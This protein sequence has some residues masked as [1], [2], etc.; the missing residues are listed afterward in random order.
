MLI[1]QPQSDEKTAETRPYNTKIGREIIFL[2]SQ[3]FLQAVAKTARLSLSWTSLRSMSKQ[4]W[5]YWVGK[6]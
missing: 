2:E 3:D 1:D 6:A 4:L 5:M